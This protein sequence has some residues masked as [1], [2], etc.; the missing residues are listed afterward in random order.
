MALRD[1]KDEAE[2][3]EYWIKPFLTRLGFLMV[4]H[5]HGSE[6]QGKDFFF[7][8]LDRFEHLRLYAGQV[9]VGNIGAGD[10]EL[11]KLLNQ[12]RRCFRVPIRD[13]K[14]AEDRRISAVYVMASG[15]ISEKA[16]QYVAGHCRSEPFGENVYFLDGE[17]LEHVSRFAS[18]GDERSRHARMIGLVTECVT[19]LKVLEAIEEYADSRTATTSLPQG[20]LPCGHFAMDYYLA[21]GSATN[22]LF[23]ALVMKAVHAC[24]RVNTYRERWVLPDELPD[25][26]VNRVNELI[27]EAREAVTT[28]RLAASAEVDRLT[29]LH[30]IQVEI[31]K[32]SESI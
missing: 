14:N 31:G 22:P 4:T 7:A 13:H 12:A 6:E 20:M 9:K 24:K 28:L 25:G 5:S 2:F 30:Q 8:D 27:A 32:P 3:R 10:V 11:D 21:T 15:K 23:H 18:Y 16:K 17:Y 19:N 29:Q 26:F 1:F